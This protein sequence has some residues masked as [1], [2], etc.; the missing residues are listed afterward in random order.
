MIEKM[1]KLTFL[2][3]NREYEDF[4]VH[5][6]ELGVV[7]IQQLQEGVSS[8]QLQTALDEQTRYEQALQSLETA[9]KTYK[10]EEVPTEDIYRTSPA[11][12]LKHLEELQ[13][14]DLRIQHE[15]DDARKNVEVL[16][17]WGEFN[18]Q[19]VD[20]LAKA[21]NL[22]IFFWRSGT[23]SFLH[24]WEEMYFAT[25]VNEFDKNTYFITFSEEK[26]DIQAEQIFLPSGT[27]SQYQSQLKELNA[28]QE[29]LRGEL[30][31][32]NSNLRGILENGET[33]TRNEIQLGQVR[34]SDE[35][36]AG[37][38]LRLL[39]GWVRADKSDELTAYLDESHIF[40]EM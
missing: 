21:S 16:E 13:A 12:L 30:L 37:N 19:S 36:V 31:Y 18:S 8:P 35:R 24:Q 10:L 5:L 39:I 34:L 17:P 32:I 3:T 26:P 6:R 33:C 7:H 11:V 15:M 2:V 4:L 14:E 23:K 38:A 27:L 25:P 9:S 28:R 40:Y 1:K 29:A 20:R 22:Q